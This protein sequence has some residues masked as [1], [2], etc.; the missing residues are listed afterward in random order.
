MFEVQTFDGGVRDKDELLIVDCPEKPRCAYKNFTEI[1]LKFL[2]ILPGPSSGGRGDRI[3][4][5][6]IH[7]KLFVVRLSEIVLGG[8]L[9][10]EQTAN[11]KRARDRDRESVMDIAGTANN[12]K[13]F[14]VFK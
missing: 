12:L 5:R 8:I 11:R 9:L 6:Y 4:K 10:V 14:T 2:S 7:Q 13:N 1:S 3:K